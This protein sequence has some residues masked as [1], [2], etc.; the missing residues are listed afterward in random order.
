MMSIRIV[1]MLMLIFPGLVGTTWE[2]DQGG[3]GREV[4]RREDGLVGGKAG[5]R[6]FTIDVTRPKPQYHHHL[7]GVYLHRHEDGDIGNL[8]K[9]W[10]ACG[11]VSM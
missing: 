5:L 6:L 8:L 1:V 3:G 7:S 9:G 10:E 11:G 2:I 4:T